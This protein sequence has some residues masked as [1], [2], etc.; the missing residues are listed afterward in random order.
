MEQEL[1]KQESEGILEP[2]EYSEW[3]TPLVIVPKKDGR[4]RMCGDFKI[5]VNPVFW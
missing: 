1:E 5:T 4:L 2:M 3:A